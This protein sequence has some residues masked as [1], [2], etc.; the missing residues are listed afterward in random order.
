MVI[1]LAVALHIHIIVSEHFNGFLDGRSPVKQHSDCNS[2]VDSRI[3]VVLAGLGFGECE[4]S[5]CETVLVDSVKSG[6]R[7]SHKQGEIF[8]RIVQEALSVVEIESVHH[9]D[10]FLS[11]RRC[12]MHENG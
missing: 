2:G 10:G 4:H 11:S 3:V 1:A 8:V 7:Q 5:D 6:V 9:R 12:C